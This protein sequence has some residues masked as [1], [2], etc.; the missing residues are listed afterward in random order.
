MATA[1]QVYAA[2]NE[3]S[4]SVKRQRA[5]IVQ[6]VASITAAKI[7]LDSVA[8]SYTDEMATIQSWAAGGNPST[9]QQAQIDALADLTAEIGTLSS[10]VTQAETDLS[11]YNFEG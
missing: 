9:F 11:A 4:A 2:I 1:S 10:I 7:T 8:G 5:I 6:A 3:V